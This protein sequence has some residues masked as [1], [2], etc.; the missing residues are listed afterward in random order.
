MEVIPFSKIFCF[1]L[2]KIKYT[3]HA[4]YANEENKVCKVEYKV[5]SSN[6][7]ELCRFTMNIPNILPSSIHVSEPMIGISYAFRVS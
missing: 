5:N 2:Q 4:G 6:D 3:V 1:F 7:K